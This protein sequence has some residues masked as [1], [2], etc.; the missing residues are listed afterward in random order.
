M[1]VVL[2]RIDWTLPRRV[3]SG[4]WL[5][6][7]LDL[8]AGEVRVVLGMLAVAFDL[9]LGETAN[10]DELGERHDCGCSFK[11]AVQEERKVKAAV[12][13]RF[14]LCAYV[15]LLGVQD[16][17]VCDPEGPIDKATGKVNQGRVKNLKSHFDHVV[18]LH[19]FSSLSYTT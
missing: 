13:V 17:N 14:M 3:K 1:E 19:C 5:Y 8:V 2:V 9:W 10:L 18:H 12:P 6:L 16:S 15:K 11:Y 7:V 4:G